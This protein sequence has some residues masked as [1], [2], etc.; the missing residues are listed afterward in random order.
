[1]DRKSA[2]IALIS[3]YYAKSVFISRKGLPPDLCI[4]RLTHWPVNVEN[5]AG[6]VVGERRCLDRHEP[7]FSSV[8]ISAA[9]CVAVESGGIDR[10][11]LA[12]GK[13]RNCSLK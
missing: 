10:F 4:M 13:Q 3:G 6:F 8:S 5:G 12:Q 11:D 2:V 7:V 9:G 1:M